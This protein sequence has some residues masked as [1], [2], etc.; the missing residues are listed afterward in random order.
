MTRFRAAL[1]GALSLV[2][3][4]PAQAGACELALLLAVDVSGSVDRREY[5]VQMRGLAEGLRDPVVTEA[6]VR[7]QAVVA[8]MQWTGASRQDLTIGW[9]KVGSV[10]D[11]KALARRVETA[12]RIWTEFSTAI[13]E[14]LSFA[15]DVVI[16]AP[17]CRR[18]VIDISGDG[19]SNEGAEPAEIRPDLEALAITVNALVIRGDDEGLPDYFAQ[20]VM[21]GGNAFVVTAE[22]YDEYPERMRRKLRRETERQISADEDATIRPAALR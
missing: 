21:T 11:L 3:L 5:A 13:G 20:N 14:A 18:R 17:A 19:R 1:A 8:L 9:T 10:A 7:G 6:L 22:D 12:P 2:A 16:D 15:T 4:T